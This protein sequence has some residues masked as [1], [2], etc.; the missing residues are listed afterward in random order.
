MTSQTAEA[1]QV[2]PSPN[3]FTDRFGPLQRRW[4]GDRWLYALR[5]DEGHR[6]EA[7][8]MHGGAMTAL[9]DEVIG[10]F[11]NE[12]AGRRHVTV[13]LATTFLRP[14]RV[15]DLVEVGGEIV[16]AT[17]SMTFAEAKLRVGGGVVATASLIFKAIRPRMPD[18]DAPRG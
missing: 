14:V 2:A 4:A 3:G 5:V 16:K 8:L 6:N 17:A 11:V 10:T 7:G 9:I 1:W 15:G 12:A 13:H 18:G